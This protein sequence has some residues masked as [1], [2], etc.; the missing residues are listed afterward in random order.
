M[1][2]KI[3]CDELVTDLNDLVC[4]KCGAEP[5]Q[6]YECEIISEINEI[7]KNNIKELSLK[8]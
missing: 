4:M 2:I 3:D 8:L 1:E 5:W 7:L 6:C